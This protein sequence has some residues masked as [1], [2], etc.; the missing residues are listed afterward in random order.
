MLPS[1]ALLLSAALPRPSRRSTARPVPE[2]R[3]VTT[4][5]DEFLAVQDEGGTMLVLFGAPWCGHSKALQP[6]WQQLRAAYPK[7]VT[8]VDCVAEPVLCKAHAIRAYPTIAMVRGYTREDYDGA[9]TY[10][11]ISKWFGDRV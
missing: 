10:D 5:K 3:P 7:Y 8:Q 11:A 9:R 6:V 4:T 2:R 1:A